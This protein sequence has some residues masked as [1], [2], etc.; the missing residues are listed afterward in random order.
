MILLGQ[1]KG[2]QRLNEIRLSEELAISRP[3]LREAFRR[4]E[5]YRLAKSIPRKGTFVTPISGIDFDEIMNARRMLETHA[6]GEIAA[7]K[8]NP[9]PLRKSIANTLALLPALKQRGTQDPDG[10][11][12]VWQ[13]VTEFHFKL[14]EVCGNAYLSSFYRTISLNL[15]R[16][17]ILAFKATSRWEEDVKDHSA[18]LDKVATGHTD[19]AKRL[20]HLHL[21][22][23][24]ETFSP[25]IERNAAAY[26][27]E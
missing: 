1:L 18:V 8:L 2:G 19:Q 16:Y 11:M 27:A 4:L 22:H 3:P 5:K 12:D 14:V 26:N 20:M 10:L 24:A 9:G 25:I 6:I 17:Q 21:D 15:A 13:A 23:F 7:K